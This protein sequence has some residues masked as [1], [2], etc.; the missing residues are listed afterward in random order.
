MLPE[1]SHRVK[2]NVRAATLNVHK[3]F[4]NV[5][6]GKLPRQSIEEQNAWRTGL[7]TL[8]QKSLTH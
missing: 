5:M 2:N 4:V 1:F 8:L 3:F 7:V 6:L